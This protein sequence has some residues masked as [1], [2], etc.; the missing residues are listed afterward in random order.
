[1]SVLSSQINIRKYRTGDYENIKKICITTGAEQLKQFKNFLLTSYCDYYIE[2][3][4]GNCFVA[5]AEN[6]NAVGYVL[7]AQDTLAWSEVFCNDYAT[8]LD[9]PF[10][11]IA[12]GACDTLLDFNTEYPAHLHIDIL[13]EYQGL[14]LGTKLIDKLVTHLRQKNIPGL[15]LSVANDNTGAQHFYEK[16]GFDVLAQYANETVMGFKL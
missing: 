16:Y 13:P 4:P 7:C 10:K 15:M 3:E 8:R 11:S 1:M 2:V 14:R 12:S 6:D 9:E 5:A